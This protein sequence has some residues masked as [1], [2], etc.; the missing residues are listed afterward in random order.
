MTPGAPYTPQTP[1]MAADHG[2]ADWHTT[3]IEVKIKESHDDEN[4]IYS[5]G[6]IRST[7]VS[8]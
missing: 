6:T 3:D 1:G 4:L 2:M 7:T 5:T 8:Q